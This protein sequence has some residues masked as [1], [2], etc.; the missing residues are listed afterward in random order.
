MQLEDAGYS[1]INS[2]KEQFHQL[3]VLS[4]AMKKATFLYKKQSEAHKDL[5]DLLP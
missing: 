4:T 5:H 1:T 3:A 2:E